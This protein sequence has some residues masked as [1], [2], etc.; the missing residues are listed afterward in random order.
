MGG[1]GPSRLQHAIG[2]PRA[3]RSI[4]FRGSL[5]ALNAHGMSALLPVGRIGGIQRPPRAVPR[6]P[7]GPHARDVVLH[8]QLDGVASQQ[9]QR[10]RRKALRVLGILR[11]AV[12]ARRIGAPA[13]GLPS[14]TGRAAP[15]GDLRHAAPCPCWFSWGG[16]PKRCFR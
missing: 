12:S 2:H 13:P 1:G 10:Q 11:G 4:Q 14:R 16:S 8:A 15:C 7:G 5:Q 3:L 6:A 9:R